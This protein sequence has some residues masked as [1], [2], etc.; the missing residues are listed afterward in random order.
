MRPELL[1]F[2]ASVPDDATVSFLLLDDHR[3]W[4]VDTVCAIFDEEV[5]NA[6]LQIPISRRGGNDFLSWPL[7]K[8]G[9]YSVRSAYQLARTQSFF[10]AQSKGG[11]GAPSTLEDDSAHWNRLW[12]IKAPGKM[13][14]NLWRFAHDCLPTGSQLV[15]RHIPANDLYGTCGREE[16]VEHCLLNC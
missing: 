12:A 14:I 4:C 1:Q 11:R 8:Y 15:R 2:C 10:V 13:K 9:D 6:V 3:S 7:T 5:A 16:I